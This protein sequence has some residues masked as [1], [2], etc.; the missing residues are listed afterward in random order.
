MTLYRAVANV[1]GLKP[2][3][4]FETDDPSSPVVLSGYVVLANP[5]T[6]EE[7]VE[8]PVEET[9]DP[10]GDI[11]GDPGDAAGG[12]DSGSTRST[13]SRTSNRSRKSNDQSAD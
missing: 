9:D 4:E 5:V 10:I 1:F 8:E 3:D 11:V 13:P 6:D 2:G 12:E 7:P